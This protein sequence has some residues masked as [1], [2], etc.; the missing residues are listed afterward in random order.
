MSLV[1][2]KNQL[3]D[4]TFWYLEPKLIKIDSTTLLYLDIVTCA[5]MLFPFFLIRLLSLYR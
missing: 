2:S 4:V 1:Y 5:A 3:E